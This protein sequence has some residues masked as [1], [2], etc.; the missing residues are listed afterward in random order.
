MPINPVVNYQQV[1][2]MAL[3]DRSSG[4][5]DIVSD[6]IP[7]FD[8]LRRKGLWETYSGPRIRQ[9]LLIDLPDIQWYAGYDFLANPPI[10]LFNDAYFTPKMAA[11][12]ISLTMEEILNNEGPNQILPVMREYIRAAEKGLAQGMELS[13]FSDGTA[14][15]GKELGGLGVA[16]PET[17][18]NVY[19]GIPRSG[20]PI[21]QTNSWDIDTDFP[22]IGTQFTD[23]TAKQILDVVMG[24][25]SRGMDHPDLILMSPQHWAAFNAQTMSIQ[26]IQNE[27]G[28]GRL[29]FRTLEYVGP[30]GVSEIV[31][32]GGRGSAM[33]DNTTFFID[34]DSFR[35]RYNPDRNF[36]TLFEGDGQKPINQ[37]AVAQFVGWMGELTMVNPLFHGRL[38]DSDP[39][40]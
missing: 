29:G 8:V 30:S 23:T 34:T 12:P 31:W 40:T 5:Q 36:D 37:D 6:A 21:W 25:M 39:A 19:G 24:E 7:L 11:V 3:E 22:T 13:L 18:D 4:W 35:M 16:I 26:R 2:S 28:V 1:L 33:P 14:F 38:Y 9:T 27:N 17:P 20:N 32:G 15:G 10:E